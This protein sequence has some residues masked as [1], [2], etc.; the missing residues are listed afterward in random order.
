MKVLILYF[1]GFLILFFGFFVNHAEKAV[2][3][4][5]K[6]GILYSASS[7]TQTILSIEVTERSLYKRKGSD[8]PVFEMFS[9]EK[10]PGKFMVKLTKDLD[11]KYYITPKPK[12]R[13]SKKKNKKAK[14]SKLKSSKN[15][16]EEEQK[17]QI[18]KLTTVKKDVPEEILNINKMAKIVNNSERTYYFRNIEKT[19][20]NVT[21]QVKSITPYQNK[22]ILTLELTNNQ[23][24]YFF[25]SNILVT[26]GLPLKVK[27]FRNPF[28]TGNKS[29][30]IYL[31]TK[32]LKHEVISIK[33]SEFSGKNRLFNLTVK[34]P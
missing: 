25:I 34:I 28:V 9:K 16:K 32:K 24:V 7:S 3:I 22:S 26:A 8:Y 6:T 12:L 4:P 17:K 11:T 1:I 18:V 19:I 33:I 13:L 30:K 10:L 20:K 2:S 5:L 23:N 31:L 15:K 27:E 29:E 14:K 21:V